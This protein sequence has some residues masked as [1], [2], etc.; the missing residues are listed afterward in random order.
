[1]LKFKCKDVGEGSDRG[2]NHVK[3]N[4]ENFKLTVINEQLGAEKI[5]DFD[6]IGRKYS[7]VRKYFKD[8]WG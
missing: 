3:I 6:L 7:D 4:P 8:L 5:Q 2:N 1:M